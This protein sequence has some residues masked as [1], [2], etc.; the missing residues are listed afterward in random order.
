MM[1]GETKLLRD[2]F[3]SQFPGRYYR[4]GSTSLIEINTAG[5]AFADSDSIWKIIVY[6]LSTL[7]NYD[8][9][10]LELQPQHLRI[11]EIKMRFDIPIPEAIFCKTAGFRKIDESTYR[12]ID[13]RQNRRYND[14]TSE[15]KGIQQSFLTVIQNHDSSSVILAFSGRYREYLSPDCLKLRYDTLIERLIAIGSIYLTQATNPAFFKVARGYEPFLPA[16]FHSMLTSANWFN[17]NYKR[18]NV[19]VNFR[20]GLYN[21]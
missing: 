14:F 1:N 6:Y 4:Y 3:S 9:L 11:H 2:Y 21:E 10:S 8:I 7:Q 12:S 13:Y 16:Q 17:G 18:R 20:G 15:S 19:T 5:F